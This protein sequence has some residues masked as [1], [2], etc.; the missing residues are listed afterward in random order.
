MSQEPTPAEPIQPRNLPEEPTPSAESGAAELETVEIPVSP[1]AIETGAAEPAAAETPTPERQSRTLRTVDQTWR[2]LTPVLRQQTLKTLKA[3]IRILEGLVARLEATPTEAAAETAGTGLSSLPIADWQQ[4]GQTFWQQVQDWWRQILPQIRARLPESINQNLSDRALTGAI[5]GLMVVLLWITSSLFSGGKPQPT[6]VAVRS[7]PQP[8]A[9]VAPGVSSTVSP[10]APA[11]AT[12][13]PGK[14]LARPKPES[15]PT[16]VAKPA[17]PPKPALKLT[18]E[19]TLIARIQDQVAE[20]SDQYVSGLIQ[21]VQ[22]NFRSSRLTVKVGE[23]W[24]GLSSNQQDKLANEILRRAREL[25]F[26]NLE[27]ID[28]EELLL[29]RSPVV[30][31]EMVV[32]KRSQLADDAGRRK[33]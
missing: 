21:S 1:T 22:A 27:M 30:G 9:T 32:L 31:S 14:P 2:G 25:D 5:A 4:R 6:T 8:S 7:S 33:G 10:S 13:A 3:A 18:P 24:Y 15:S 28:P 29:A 12:P 17:P 20:I 26:S 11:V 16:P 23:G 19:Q